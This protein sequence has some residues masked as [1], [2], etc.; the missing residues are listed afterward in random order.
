M[1]A[2]GFVITRETGAAWRLDLGVH[3]PL[4]ESGSTMATSLSSFHLRISKGREVA[5][6]RHGNTPNEGKTV[7]PGSCTPYTTSVD[8]N[9][10]FGWLARLR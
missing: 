3:R 10:L 1:L 8:A 5:A 2:A 4:R 9:L 6:S 7:T